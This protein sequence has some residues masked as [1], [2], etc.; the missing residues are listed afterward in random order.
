MTAIAQRNQPD[1]DELL[2]LARDRS[3][4]SRNRLVEILSGL[5]E[6]GVSNLPV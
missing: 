6:S 1:V 5:F 2:A 3:T 4:A